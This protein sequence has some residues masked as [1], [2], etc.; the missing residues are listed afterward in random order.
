MFRARANIAVSLLA[1]LALGVTTVPL[2][3]AAAAASTTAPAGS[4]STHN[5]AQAAAGWLA[6]QMVGGSH[7]TETF[8]GATF[9]DQ[10]LTIDAIY[11]FAAT[12]TATGYAARAM[13]WLA[14]PHILANYIGN[15]TTSAYAGATANL[16]LGAEVQGADPDTFGGV[17]LPSRLA[18]LL[19]ASGRY[20]DKSKFGDF[21]NVFSQSLAIIAMTRLSGA[22][23]SA[24]KFLAS[25][26]CPDGGFPLN[27][28]KKK[29]VADPDATA[30]VVQALLAAHRPTPAERGLHWLASVQQSDGGFVSP[31]A[32]TANS[33]STGLAG[34]AFVAGGWFKRAVRARGFLLSVQVGC[35]GPSDQQGAIAYDSSG[36]NASTAAFAT[37]QGVLGVADVPL[38]WLGIHPSRLGAPRLACSS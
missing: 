38:L 3:S 30:M 28:G 4:T 18:S 23:A 2:A 35:A 33:N 8:D 37:A 27:F 34:E 5:P 21:S 1:T 31:P 24:V 6:R 19:T 29:C 7:F 11:A 15:G 16:L 10:G 22:P 14:R 26:E 17:D 20:S 9:P 32:T 13:G 36:F 12:G 25:S